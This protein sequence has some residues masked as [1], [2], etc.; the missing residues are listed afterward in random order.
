MVPARLLLNLAGVAHT[1]LANAVLAGCSKSVCKPT[2]LNL[3]A[4]ETLKQLPF[5][6]TSWRAVTVASGLYELHHRPIKFYL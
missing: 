6:C 4:S 3:P 5:D 1:N 2:D